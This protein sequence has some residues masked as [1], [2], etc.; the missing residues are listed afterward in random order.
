MPGGDGDGGSR[1]LDASLVSVAF[2]EEDSGRHLSDGNGGG[3]GRQQDTSLVLLVFQ[4]DSGRH[5]PGGNGDEGRRQQDTSLVLMAFQEDSRIYLPD[6]GGDDIKGF[7]KEIVQKA[8]ARW[9]NIER[10]ENIFEISKIRNKI[11]VRYEFFLK[12][13]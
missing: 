12:N 8:I 1:Q 4:E 7:L 3:E 11:L 13:L 9:R 6:V 10:R 2:Q 5:V